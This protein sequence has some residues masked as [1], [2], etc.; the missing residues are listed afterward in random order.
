[1][2]D[3]G[4]SS[5]GPDI[6]DMSEMRRSSREPEELRGLLTQWLTGTLGSDAKP[7]VLQLSGTSA[8][9]MSSETILFDARWTEDGTTSDH[10]WLV[11]HP[12][13]PTSRCFPTTTSGCSSR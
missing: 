12:I 13:R 11:W 9:G 3:T 2:A 10:S 5:D 4:S 6:P 7:E 1:M 8:T